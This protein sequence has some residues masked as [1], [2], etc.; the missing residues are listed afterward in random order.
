MSHSVRWQNLYLM[1]TLC[2]KFDC[3][4]SKLFSLQYVWHKQTLW[5]FLHCPFKLSFSSNV[6][7]VSCNC[8]CGN[9]KKTSQKSHTLFQPVFCPVP[10]NVLS[11]SQGWRSSLQ[12]RWHRARCDVYSGTC[13]LLPS[14]GCSRRLIYP[15]CKTDV[16]ST[17][18]SMNIW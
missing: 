7:V 11:T 1:W 18:L 13:H 15:G 3:R 5:Q 6:M 2:N 8:T 14:S 16:I 9:K 12:G 4:L 17:W 10:S